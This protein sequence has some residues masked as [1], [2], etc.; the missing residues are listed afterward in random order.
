MRFAT[1]GASLRH[2]RNLHDMDDKPLLKL[3]EAGLGSDASARHLNLAPEH[4]MLRVRE[5]VSHGILVCRGDAEQVDW[6]AYGAWKRS[7]PTQPA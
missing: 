3:L 4:V 6:R 1:P 2:L 5:Y 7:Q